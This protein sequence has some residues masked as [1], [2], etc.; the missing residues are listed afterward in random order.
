MGFVRYD[1]DNRKRLQ[2]PVPDDAAGQFHAIYI[3]FD[4][5]RAVK[6]EGFVH[7]VLQIGDWPYD[8]HAHTGSAYHRFDN[9]GQAELLGTG[10]GIDGII[11]MIDS[12]G[13]GG[14]TGLFVDLLGGSFVHGKR[15]SKDPRTLIG[16]V[17][18]I[19]QTLHCAIFSIG[20]VK[21]DQGDVDLGSIFDQAG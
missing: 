5:N 18:Q 3:A 8:R 13:R 14:N 1:F 19:K 16:K 2:F 12:I 21:D 9:Q 20:P 15:T 17:E 6:F 7:S 4:H 10:I 11:A